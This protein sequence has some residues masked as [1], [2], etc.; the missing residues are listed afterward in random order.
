MY[1]ELIKQNTT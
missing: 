1:E